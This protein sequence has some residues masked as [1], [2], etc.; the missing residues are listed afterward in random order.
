M[1][2]CW[3]SNLFGLSLTLTYSP[4][5]WLYSWMNTLLMMPPSNFRLISSWV[6]VQL[7]KEPGNDWSNWSH[8]PILEIIIMARGREYVDGKSLD[9]VSTSGEAMDLISL[10][11]ESR[12]GWFPHRKLKVWFPGKRKGNFGK[13]RRSTA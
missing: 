5:C 13:A 6:H 2:G 1:P 7:S 12:G 11:P 8:V 10:C 9:Y 4:I 3:S